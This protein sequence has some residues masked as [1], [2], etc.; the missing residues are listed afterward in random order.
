MAGFLWSDLM[1]RVRYEAYAVYCS[2][3]TAVFKVAHLRR[4]NR[5]C[6]AISHLTAFFGAL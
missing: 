5:G 2:D 1:R 3:V 4:S 6:E